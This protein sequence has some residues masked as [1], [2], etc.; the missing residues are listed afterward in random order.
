MMDVEHNKVLPPAKGGK[1]SDLTGIS[2]KPTVTGDQENDNVG[3]EKKDR[4]KRRSSKRRS[5][6]KRRSS[7]RSIGDPEGIEIDESVYSLATLEDDSKQQEPSVT[8]RISKRLSIDPEGFESPS[9]IQGFQSSLWMDELPE[10]QTGK[11]IEKEVTSPRKDGEDVTMNGFWQRQAKRVAH[12]PWIH[13]NVSLIVASILSGIAMTLG[14]FNV[15]AENGGWQSRGTLIA[16]RE[17]QLM[18]A[19]GYQEFLFNGG[20]EA[21]KELETNVQPGWENEDTDTLERRRLTTSK[22][23]GLSSFA[24]M[25]AGRKLLPFSLDERLLQMIDQSES[26]LPGCDIS[27]YTN[28][29]QLE[30]E[31]HL[32][33]IWQASSKKDTILDPDLLLDICASEENT[34]AVLEENGLC[35]G[36]DD[37]CL[38]PFSVVL[39]ARLTIP[40]GF[41]MKCEELSMKWSEY[42]ASTE[43]GWTQCVADMKAT[44]D[45]TKTK[46]EVP[47]SCPPGFSPTLV[48]E[49]FDETSW[50][51]YSS[52]I[53]ATREEHVDALYELLDEF[54]RGTDKVYGAYDTQR[55]DFNTIY[56]D[57][58]VGRDM[59][60][61]CG[62]AFVTALAIL[63]HTRSPFITLIGL[64]QIILS[65]PLSFFVYTFIGGLE[66]FPFLNFIGVFVVFALGA[67]DIFVAVDKW[68]NARLEHPNA[69]TEFV[70]AIALPDAACSMFLTTI[71]TAIAFFGTAICPVAPIKLFAIFC[72]LLIMFDYLMC[73]M[74]VFP[75]LCIYDRRLRAGRSNCCFACH[76]CHRFEAQSDDEN[77]DIEKQS[78]IRRILYA[79]YA[80][81][82]RVRWFLLFA[83][84]AG[85]AICV[86]FATTL[87]LP[88][89]ADVR[90]LEE[91]NEFEQNYFWRQ[92][93]LYDA[94][95]KSE[96]S[97]VLV[98]FGLAPADTGDLRT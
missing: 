60:L 38:P 25:N 51:T 81:L 26:L 68:K 76:C 35:F 84:L 69:S 22:S 5:G 36:C 34:Q 19:S 56:V 64:L 1:M 39:Y 13:L 52:S 89:S 85:F 70:A 91:S 47:A 86:Y 77:A 63:L 45:P 43:S 71:T 9:E 83:C 73:I 75:A 98:G 49:T 88:T 14:D 95:R 92:K 37:G 90:I 17:T 44:F 23:T 93:L 21:W 48:E 10:E 62:S 24:P 80:G 59:A 78:L 94:L 29:T 12:S 16:N 6:S 61:A 67:D 18:M 50:V 7:R 55:E 97:D 66:F 87:E 72:G 33:P 79:F 11:V 27:W 41:Q 58:A 57:A 32:W 54:D 3:G 8:K 82:H 53:F 20:P 46:V 31:T 65:F 30:K 40:G 42:Q 74:L 28:W 2:P 96:G 4:P 15:T